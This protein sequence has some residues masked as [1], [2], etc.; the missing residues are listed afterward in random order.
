MLT[1]LGVMVYMALG[2]II[3]MI[4]RRMPKDISCSAQPVA[5]M[6]TWPIVVLIW[7]VDSGAMLMG[8]I[9]SLLEELLG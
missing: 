3:Y 4:D 7:I 2:L 5:A 8:Y 6:T 1:V 9:N